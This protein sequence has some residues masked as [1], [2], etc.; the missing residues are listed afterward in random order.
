MPLKSGRFIRFLKKRACG[1]AED[2]LL[3]YPRYRCTK[4]KRKQL[5]EDYTSASKKRKVNS[6]PTYLNTDFFSMHIYGLEV[7]QHTFRF[8]VCLQS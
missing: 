4:N 8:G 7:S 3:R 1:T 5:C 2:I 6:D